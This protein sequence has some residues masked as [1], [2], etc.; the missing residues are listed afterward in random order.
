MG[1]F[2]QKYFFLKAYFINF[3]KRYGFPLNKKSLVRK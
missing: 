3:Q 2:E 1:C